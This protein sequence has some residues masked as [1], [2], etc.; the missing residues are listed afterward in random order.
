MKYVPI[1]LCLCLLLADAALAQDAPDLR[2]R[3]RGGAALQVGLDGGGDAMREFNPSTITA[4]QGVSV[5]LGGYYRPIESSPFEITGLIGG[6]AGFFFPVRGGGYESNTWR[7]MAQVL[8]NYRF[9]NKWYVAGGLVYHIS[10]RFYDDDPAGT[11]VDFKNALGVTAEFGWSFIGVQYTYM[12][13]S[14]DAFGDFDASNVGLRFTM[15]FR[16]WHPIF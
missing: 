1:A 5:S 2:P 6:K 11:D 9:N 3:H 8:G 16:K 13:Y 10:P 14:S 12:R 15:H 4:G 7:V